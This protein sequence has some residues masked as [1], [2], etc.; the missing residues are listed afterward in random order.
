VPRFSSVIRLAAQSQ[1]PL[2]GEP[3]YASDRV[4]YGTLKV[5]NGPD[6]DFTLAIDRARG[7]PPVI[8]FDH[9]NDK[10]LSNDGPGRWPDQVS[11]GTHG[12][13]YVWNLPIN[14]P[15]AT[16]PILQSFLIHC[17]VDGEPADLRWF[18]NACRECTVESQGTRYRILLVASSADA[19]FD[20]MNAA[21]VIRLAD[22]SVPAPGRTRHRGISLFELSGENW[23]VVRVS[24]DGTEMTWEPVRGPA[25]QQPGKP[26]AA[27]AP[28]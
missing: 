20:N 4:Q 3:E 12:D 7:E 10:D 19:C 14:V 8:Y 26:K 1:E 5:G 27:R 21:L 22:D 25:N 2:G 15:Y 6:P 28:P 24:A 23:K 13:H 18:L 11:G 17:P 9:N 16:G